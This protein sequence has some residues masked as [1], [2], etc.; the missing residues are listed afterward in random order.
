MGFVLGKETLDGAIVAHEILHSIVSQKIPTMI[1]KL[2][3]MKAYDRVD[4]NALNLVLSKFGFGKSW[5]KWIYTCISVDRFLVLIN[6]SP[7]G[8]FSSSWGVRQ[9]D[10]L[11]PFLF[12]NMAKSFS[13]AIRSARS[14]GL[15]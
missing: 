12:I 6:G 5:I 7:C 15:W 8:L 9:G 1:V 13:R 14:S 3:M 4:W 11:S 10:P 2:D